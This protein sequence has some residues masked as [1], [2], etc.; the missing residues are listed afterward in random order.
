MLKKLSKYIKQYKT[1][2]ILTVLFTVGEVVF[3]VAIPYMIGAIIDKGISAGNS[4]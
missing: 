1:S 2:T 3:E 4:N